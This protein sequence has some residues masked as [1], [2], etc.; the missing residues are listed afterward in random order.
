MQ[1]ALSKHK[2]ALESKMPTKTQKATTAPNKELYKR[3]S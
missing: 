3:K 2:I 1:K